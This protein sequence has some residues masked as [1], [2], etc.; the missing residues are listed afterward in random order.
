MND[1]LLPDTQQGM[2]VTA[3]YAVLDLK[4]AEL[5]YVNAGHN[6]PLWLK[7]SGEIEKLTRTAVAL[8]VMEQSTMRQRT[9]L[10][11][12]GETVLL[13]TDGLTEAFSADNEFYGDARLLE[14]LRSLHESSAEEVLVSVESHLN[15]FTDPMPPADDM[16]MLAVRRV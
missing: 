12:V 1:L 16:T 11:E 10:L 15:E 13:Y 2:F 14:R 6:P 9:I 8:G 5:T 3:V 7:R 4:R